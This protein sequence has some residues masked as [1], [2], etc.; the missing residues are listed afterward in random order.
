MFNSLTT[1]ITNFVIYTR[2]RLRTDMKEFP[3]DSVWEFLLFIRS[4][5]A[6]NKRAR[7]GRKYVFNMDAHNAVRYETS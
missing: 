5:I 4:L 1:S 3:L 6:P 2:K 7:L